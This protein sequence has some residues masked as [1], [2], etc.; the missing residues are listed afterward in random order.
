MKLGSVLLATLDTYASIS[1]SRSK[2]ACRVQPDTVAPD[3]RA[4]DA[5]YSP[6]RFSADWIVAAPIVPSKF[7]TRRWSEEIMR[8]SGRTQREAP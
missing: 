5:G 4:A 7:L 3:I 2:A 8:P 6:L 1:P